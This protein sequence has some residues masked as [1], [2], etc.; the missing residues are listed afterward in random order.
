MKERILKLLRERSPQTTAEIAQKVGLSWHTAH[1]RL[2][3][4]QVEGKIRRMKVGG[5]HLWF[6]EEGSDAGK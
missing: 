1:E 2:L 3:E 5:R 4:L 6:Y